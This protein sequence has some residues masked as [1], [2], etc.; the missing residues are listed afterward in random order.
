[1]ALNL[2][3]IDRA[4]DISDE[5]FWAAVRVP[6]GGKNVELLR[7]AIALAKRKK[8]DDAY[9]ALAAHHRIALAPEWEK[10][11]A[12]HLRR[13]APNAQKLKDLLRLKINAWHLQMVEFDKKIDWFPVRLPS[14]CRHGFHY[15]GWLAPA[16]TALIQT[17]EKQYRDFMIDVFEQYYDARKDKRWRVDIRPLVYS[18]LGMSGRTPIILGGYLALLALGEIPS[19]TVAAVVKTFLGFGRQ[20]DHLLREYVP[21]NNG[22]CVSTFTLQHLSLAFPEWNESPKWNKKAVGFLL[23]QA[24]EGFYE[25]GGNKER[26]W[27]YGLMHV[28]ALSN[29]YDL[30]QIYGGLGKH[31]ALILNTLRKCYQWY[32]KSAGPDPRGFYPTYGDAGMDNHIGSIRDGLRYFPEKKPDSKLKTKLEW[33]VDRSK[34]YLLD[35][36]GFAIMRNGNH[37][38]ASYINVDFGPFA[39]W[40]S[41]WDLLSMN[42]W[43]QGVRLL[44]EQCRFGPYACPLD[45]LF[46]APESHNLCLIDGM[47]YDNRD[48]KGE[49]VAWH[50][51]EKIDYFSATHRAYR[52][53]VFGREGTKVSPNIEAL[54]RRTIVLVKDPGYAVVLDSVCDI[55]H[56]IFNRAVSQYWH[57]PFPFKPLGRDRVRIGKERAALMVWAQP[58]SLHRLDPGV[59]FAGAEVAHLGTTEDRYNLRARRWLPLDHAGKCSGFTTVI[60]PFQGALPRVDVRVLPSRGGGPWQTEAIEITTPAGRDVI[61][62]NPEH[63]RD[64]VVDG[65]KISGRAAI[66]LGNGRGQV[67]VK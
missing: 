27:G 57:S 61:A 50:S 40:H 63:M 62:L 60:Y 53:F 33:G 5:Q 43:S 16:V 26:V 65:K 3:I 36:S 52:Y 51:D 39:G 25:D 21:A 2:D 67:K 10:I 24:R 48:V 6:Q 31:D 32:A 12:G 35:A 19:K 44:E 7:E 22:F 47:I 1:M 34:S 13:S 58:E 17:G 23:Q 37:P 49:N 20:L 9:L 41:H 46:R 38:D 42:F 29:A 15:M 4:S 66:T 8:F 18:G 64:F 56:A 55:N 45:T 54:V 59:D 11:R 28:G 30:A 14:D